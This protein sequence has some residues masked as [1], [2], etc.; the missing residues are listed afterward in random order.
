MKI[1]IMKYKPIEKPEPVMKL[2]LC[3]NLN[4]VLLMAFDSEGVCHNI[5]KIGQEGIKLLPH[6]T[7][8]TGWPIDKDGK[9]KLLD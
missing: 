8:S 3:K 1:S 2:T 6:R 5:A 9:L 7:M 4:Y